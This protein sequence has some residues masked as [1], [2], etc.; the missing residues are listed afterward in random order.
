MSTAYDSSHHDPAASLGPAE[1]PAVGR[2][3]TEQHLHP[4][5]RPKYRQLPQTAVYPSG[6]GEERVSCHSLGTD[7]GSVEKTAAPSKLGT[8]RW[9]RFSKLFAFEQ[10]HWSLELAAIGLSISSLAAIIILLTLYDTKPLVSWTWTVSFN[11]V[12]STLSATSRATLA[13]AIS[14][15]ISQGKWNWY[16]TRNEQVVAFDRFEEASRGP[17]G[18][19]RLL[20]WT[21]LR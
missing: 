1:R 20:W 13:F 21:R 5:L 18:S 12:I 17:W 8:S 6:D 4:F 3:S 9:H 14:A 16:R 19:L 7:A 15:C 11:A 2:A 10:H